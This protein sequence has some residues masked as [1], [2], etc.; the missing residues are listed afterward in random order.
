MLILR[1]IECASYQNSGAFFRCSF[2]AYFHWHL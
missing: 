2:K 1:R